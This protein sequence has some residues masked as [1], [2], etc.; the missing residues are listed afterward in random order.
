MTILF[1]RGRPWAAWNWRRFTGGMAA[2]LGLLLVAYVGVP[3][4]ASAASTPLASTSLQFS[5]AQAT[6]TPIVL[7]KVEPVKGF[8]GEPFTVRGEGLPPDSE[9]EFVWV[10]WEG[11]YELNILPETIEFHEPVFTEIR[12]TLGQATTDAEGRLEVDLEA[13]A[14]YGGA[15]DI[16]AVLDGQDVAKGG[17]QIQRNV[18]ITPAEGPVGTPITIE[19][20]GLGW[21]AL[22]RAMAVRYSNQYIGYVTGVTTRGSSTVQIRAAGP[23]G[24]HPIELSGLGIHGGGYLNNQQ[25]PYAH[26]FPDI[27]SYR[28]LFTVTE[29]LGAPVD[30][31]EW[32]AGDREAW[33]SSSITRTTASALPLEGDAV[34][35]LGSGSGP[36]LSEVALQVNGLAPDSAVELFWTT[37]RGNRVS[38]SGWQLLEIPLLQE[39]ADDEGALATSFEVPDD[40]G[41]WHVVKLVQDEQV[42]AEVPYYVEQNLVEVTPK[43]VQAGEP[44]TI[45]IKGVGWTELDNTVAV[46][47]NNAYMGYACGFNSNGDITLHM[48]ATGGA[49]THLIDI[50]PTTYQGKGKRPWG[51]QMPHLSALQDHP[52]LALEYS[53]PIYRLAIEVIE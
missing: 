3:Q 4:H 1:C 9:L 12:V 25:S 17:F 41:G 47:Y 48:I 38:P 51:F 23:P 22:E 40:L 44:F 20:T 2:L 26:L 53:L 50:Y 42:V 18:T 34:A 15:H 45:Q 31:I 35:V 14:D 27:G 16:F 8:G 24:V 29:D 49:G 36:I 5:A 30:S 39:M 21:K 10:T 33:L 52:S 28:S 19:V 13:P 37:A 46:T 43:Q 32:P 11:S 7:L 6:P